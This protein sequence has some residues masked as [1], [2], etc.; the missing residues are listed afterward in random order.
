LDND[1]E[2]L[3]DVLQACVRAGASVSFLLPFSHD[4]AK[5]FW[6][7]QVLPAVISHSRCVLIVRLGRKI[8]GTVQL[9]FAS[10]PNQPPRAE[11]RKLLVHPDARRRGI[12]KSLMSAV[13]VQARIEACLHSIQRRPAM[14]NN[15][16]FL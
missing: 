12:A 16:I 11:I 15:Y 6:S 14:P 8:V 7:S 5:P 1:I 4:E 3:G 10:P 2:M 9:D 13:E